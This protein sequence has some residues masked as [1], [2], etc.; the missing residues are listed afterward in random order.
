[1]TGH[2]FWKATILGGP[3]IIPLYFNTLVLNS[4]FNSHIVQV[5][6]LSIIL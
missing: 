2:P 6:K 4:V 5:A 3:Y 1:M